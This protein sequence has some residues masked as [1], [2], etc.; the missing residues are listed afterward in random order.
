MKNK[1]KEFINKI[2]N[3][4][5]VKYFTFK[6]KRISKQYQKGSTYY[7]AIKNCYAIYRGDNKFYES[8]QV[9]IPE[10]GT[11]FYDSRTVEYTNLQ[12]GLFKDL[13][14]PAT[15][16]IKTDCGPELIN[17]PYSYKSKTNG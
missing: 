13:W 8:R 9:L 10:I 4:C 16:E 12:I 15:A 2:I 14:V 17:N 11:I 6:G 5:L 1:I 7:N 3:W